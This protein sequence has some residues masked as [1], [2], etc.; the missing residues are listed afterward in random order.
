[1]RWSNKDIVAYKNNKAIEAEA[2]F[3]KKIAIIT[4]IIAVGS[5]SYLLYKYKNN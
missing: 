3:Y 2:V 5:L 4:S 1:M